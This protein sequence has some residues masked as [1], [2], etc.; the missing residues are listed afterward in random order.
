MTAHAT[1]ARVYWIS[2][3]ISSQFEDQNQGPI[4]QFCDKSDPIATIV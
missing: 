3:A 2:G 4:A 1:A